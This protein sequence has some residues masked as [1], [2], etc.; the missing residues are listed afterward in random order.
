[1][2]LQAVGEGEGMFM[3]DVRRLQHDDLGDLIPLSRAFFAEYAGY[4]P[5]FFRLARLNDEDIVAY[6]SGFLERDDRA[7][8][9]ALRDG[10]IVGYIAVKIRTQPAYWEVRRAGHISGLMVEKEVRREGIGTRLLER[11]RG[12][13]RE[14]GVMY[15]TVYTA[16]RNEEAVAFYEARGMELL[17]RHLLGQVNGD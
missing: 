12:Y 15:Y 11:V 5:D 3:V 17:Y 9:V 16:V 1:V 13:F 10:R 6:F 4:H 14:Q 7:A 8:F 2:G